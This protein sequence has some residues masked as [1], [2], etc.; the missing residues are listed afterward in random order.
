M[1][2]AKEWAVCDYSKYIKLIKFN[3]AHQKLQAW[4]N[5]PDFRKRGK[6]LPKIQAILLKIAPSD[7]LY[8]CTLL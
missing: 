1:D 5:L 3:L 2:T 6:T 4:E 8:K 7:L